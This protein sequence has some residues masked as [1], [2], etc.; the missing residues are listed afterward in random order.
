MRR[1][2]MITLTLLAAVTLVAG[3]KLG[4]PWSGILVTVGVLLL[5]AALFAWGAYPGRKG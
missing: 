5:V 4:H 3:S 1:R 2:W